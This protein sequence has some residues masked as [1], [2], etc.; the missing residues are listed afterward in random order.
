MTRIKVEVEPI[1]EPRVVKMGDMRPLQIGRLVEQSDRIVMRTA[2]THHFEVIAFDGHVVDTWTTD[3]CTL[4]V[5]LFPPH[6]KVTLN[7]EA[8][9]F[10]ARN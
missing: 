7:L 6:T 5:E 1:P 9:V 10:P 2:S 8:N 3:H 4:L